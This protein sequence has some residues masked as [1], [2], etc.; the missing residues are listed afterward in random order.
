MRLRKKYLDWGSGSSKITR[1]ETKPASADFVAIVPSESPPAA[2]HGAC[3]SQP[4]LQ[5]R[6]L[7]KWMNTNKDHSRSPP[8]LTWHHDE[9]PGL[10][11]LVDFKDHA[12][13]QKIYHPE[14]KGGRELWGGG[15]PGRRGHLNKDGTIKEGYRG[16]Y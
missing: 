14:R 9:T 5:Y 8:G 11:K 16:R 13:Q 3:E 2:S 6:K 1:N 12:K 7:E 4:A 10:L 15:E